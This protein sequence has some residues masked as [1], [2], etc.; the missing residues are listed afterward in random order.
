MGRAVFVEV[1]VGVS[2]GD[3]VKVGVA[4]AEVAV[5]TICSGAPAVQAA[6][7]KNRH[8]IG[9]FFMIGTPLK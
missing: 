9:T 4:D 8:K 3:G 1:A 5:T 7:R 2:L 6:A